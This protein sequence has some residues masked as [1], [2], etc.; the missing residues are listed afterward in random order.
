LQST[1][2]V[3]PSV[4]YCLSAVVVFRSESSLLVSVKCLFM[5]T[6]WRT[7]PYKY[8]VPL[9]VQTGKLFEGNKVESNRHF[10]TF[11]YVIL[12]DTSFVCFLKF[13]LV[14]TDGQRIVQFV[15]M[16]NKL[17]ILYWWVKY[18]PVC[19]D[20]PHIVQFVLM[21]NVSSNLYWYDNILS[22]LYW[23]ATYIPVCT[24]GPRIVQ[25]YWWAT[26][27]PI[28]TGGPR[29]V[30]FVLMGHVLPNLYWWAIY[31]PIFRHSLK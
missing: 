2:R 13:L 14:F 25:F 31:Y 4:V 7:F 3:K 19:T 16:G 22:N 12:C 21:D 15:L 17:P 30:Q 26:Y 8:K 9:I 24:D 1:L 28:C 11:S 20:G 27:C 6:D 5:L 29:I 10:V 23:W 18:C